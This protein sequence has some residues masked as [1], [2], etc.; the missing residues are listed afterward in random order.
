MVISSIYGTSKNNLYAVGFADNSDGT[1][2]GIILKYDGINWE[3]INIPDIRVGFNEIKRLKNGKYIINGIINDDIG[4]LDKLFIFDGIGTLK[5]IYSDY[6]Y[7]SLDEM[8]NE[9][10]IT[11][12]NKIYK[13]KD[14][15]LKLWKE[16]SG[17]PYYDSVLGRSEKDFFGIGYDGILHFNGIDLVNIYKSQLDISASIIF[18]KD[19]F[20]SGYNRQTGIYVMIRGTLKE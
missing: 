10:Y 8:N 1:G 14:D 20:F 3:F 2:K 18:E 12:N 7:P 17:I 19:V 15:K 4:F 11:I 5:E 16:F 13:C 9:V 6:S